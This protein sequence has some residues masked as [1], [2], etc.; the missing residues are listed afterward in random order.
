MK[1]EAKG[2][3]RNSDGTPIVVDGQLLH[4]ARVLCY[5][6]TKVLDG[7]CIW[8]TFP[9]VNAADTDTGT[10]TCYVYTNKGPLII[11]G[12]LLKIDCKQTPFVL[13]DRVTN[14]FIDAWFPPD[15]DNWLKEQLSS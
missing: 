4:G 14:K 2:L 12:K 8:E 7:A 11:A 1:V 6:P 13:V 3:A 10:L 5:V 9:M 15:Y